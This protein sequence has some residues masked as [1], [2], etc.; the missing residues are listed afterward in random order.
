MINKHLLLRHEA[1]RWV[2]FMERGGN[3]HGQVVEMFQSVVG[4]ANG[5]AWCMSFVQ[6]CVMQ[7]DLLLETLNSADILTVLPEKEHCWDTW[8]YSKGNSRGRDPE[9]GHVAIWKHK[10]NNNGHTGIVVGF[11]KNDPS[12]F[13]TVEGNTSPTGGDQREGDGV[14]LK[15][16]D[17]IG[18]G[19]LKLMG[20]LDP[21]PVPK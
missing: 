12:L 4:G 9:I 13:Y 16:R 1:S 3:N 11:H 7:T 17:K 14:F 21:W 10:D 5:E 19:K 20:F 6:Y 15:T 2:G 18:I 8:K